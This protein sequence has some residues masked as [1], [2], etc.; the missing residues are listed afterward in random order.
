MSGKIDLDISKT[1]RYFRACSGM[2]VGD[3][4][5][6]FQMVFVSELDLSKQIF[7]WRQNCDPNNVV[8]IFLM[9]RLIFGSTAASAI[10]RT[11]LDKI[12]EIGELLC[13]FCAGAFSRT[14]PEQIREKVCEGISHHLA[15]ITSVCYVDDYVFGSKNNFTL[16]RIIDYAIHLFALFSY[17]FKGIDCNN[18]PFKGESDTVDAQG[19]MS[20]CGYIWNPS[21][22]CM[23]LKKIALH[24]GVMHRGKITKVKSSKV[25][26]TSD[27]RIQVLDCK[28]K[29]TL[30]NINKLLEGKNKT[31][32]VLISLCAQHYDPLG[33]AN[34]CLTQTHNTV[35]LAMKNSL[36]QWDEPG[37]EDIWNFFIAQMI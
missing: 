1:A 37:I 8:E 35:S 18:Q 31:L 30:E 19:N 16:D 36:G 15:Q 12:I 13:K 25:G 2:A 33:L 17:E 21:C 22:D 14:H 20:V 24:N 23:S 28:E 26:E 11:S 34:A 5:K 6:F 10:A 7:I 29:I 9:T 4:R 3:I 32:R 27:L